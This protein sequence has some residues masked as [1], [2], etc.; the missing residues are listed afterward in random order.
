MQAVSCMIGQ[1]LLDRR[2]KRRYLIADAISVNVYFKTNEIIL[3]NICWN[4]FIKTIVNTAA[5]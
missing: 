2:K 1:T 4:Y 3:C 5:H